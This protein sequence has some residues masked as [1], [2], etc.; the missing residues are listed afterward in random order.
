[1]ED[2]QPDSKI[3]EF[4]FIIRYFYFVS[5]S[6]VGDLVKL[7]YKRFFFAVGLWFVVIPMSYNYSYD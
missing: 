6:Y 7:N 3:E 5:Q 1:M 2:K 4:Y